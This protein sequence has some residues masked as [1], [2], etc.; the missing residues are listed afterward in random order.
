[1]DDRSDSGWG[2]KLTS[3]KHVHGVIR[4]FD[5]SNGAWAA[6]FDED[7]VQ[8]RGLQRDR[9]RKPA[10]EASDPPP[11]D[12]P[13][14]YYPPHH[15]SDPGPQASYSTWSSQSSNQQ[16]QSQ[17]SGDSNQSSYHATQQNLTGRPQNSFGYTHQSSA[18]PPPSSA[19]Y[20]SYG[21]GYPP[22][23][24]PSGSNYYQGSQ[25]SHN[26]TTSP[27]SYGPVSNRLDSNFSNSTSQPYDHR[28]GGHNQN[29]NEAN[30]I[31]GDPYPGPRPGRVVSA[32]GVNGC[33]YYLPDNGS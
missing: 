10:A 25:S 32:P 27:T 1:M 24:G 18:S 3:F 23:P 31:Y 6:E 12:R 2:K 28:Q 9:K 11:A 16:P 8:T 4:H 13:P 5:S 19:N 33:P 26:Y 20:G 30:G 29:Q 7:V 21:R 15:M 17:Y 22:P 14:L